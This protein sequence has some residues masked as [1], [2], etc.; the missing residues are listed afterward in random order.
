MTHM[1][2][3]FDGA[4]A[5]NGD[6]SG[7]ET[8]A[9]TSMQRMFNEAVAF[10]SDISSWNTSKV[11][12]MNGMF[13]DA[14]SFNQDISSWD[15]TSVTNA[16]GM[17]GPTFDRNLGKWYVVL[18]NTDIARAPVPRIV[19]E[20]SSQNLQFGRPTYG[21]GDGD[22]KD[23]FEIVNDNQI[24][25]TSIDTK[26][27]YEVNV[28]ASS[29]GGIDSIFSDG[30][31]WRVFDVTVTSEGGT[32]LT[33]GAFV[34]TWETESDSDAVRI[35]L[36]VRSGET[37]TID[38]GDNSPVTVVTTNV[39]RA[40]VYSDSG[41]YQVSMT[42]GL[43]RIHLG[44][45]GSTP[46]FLT[47]IDQWGDDIE[48]S[49]MEGAFQGAT[50][51]EYEA[52]DVPD[53][54]DVT[55]MKDMFREATAFNGDISSWNVASVTDTSSM[56]SET[57][58][59]NQPLNDWNV[60]SVTDMSG[61]FNGA[62]AF[63]QPLNDWTVDS[64]TDMSSMFSETYVFNQPLNDWNVDS[65]TDMSGM[66]SG[67]F[68]FNRP[69]NDWNVDSVTDM[70]GM[71][72]G[73]TDFNRPLN[74]WNVDSV[75][76]MENM[77]AAAT[78][79]NED[80]S[81]WDVSSVT[82]M[83]DM[84]NGADSFNRN[85]GKWYVVLNN[86]DIDRTNVPGIVGEISA[87][88]SWLDS[89][90]LTYDIGTGGDSDL[91]D[92]VNNNDLNMDSVEQKSAYDVT[93]VVSGSGVFGSGAHSHPLEITVTGSANRAPTADAGSDLSV[94]EGGSIAPQGSGSDDDGD[95]LTYSWSQSPATPVVSFG[96]PT[97]ATQTITAPSV[98]ADTE[99]TLT[100]TVNDGTT[101][102][103]D[104]MVLTVRDVT[105]QNLRPTVNVGPNQ[106]VREGAPVSMPWTA[107]DPDADPLTFS[108]S[109]DPASPAISLSSPNSSPTT[110][111]APQ[112]DVDTPFTFTLQVTAGPHTVEDSLTVTVKNN[113]P[114]AVDAGQDRT[115]SEG[116]PVTL[117]GTASDPDA[118]PLTYE[119]TQD[120]GP[121]VTLTNDGTARPQFT[122]PRV[123][124]DQEIVF[125][126][127]VTDDPGES[128]DDTVT[129][130]VRDVPLSVSS[131][132]YNPGSGQL[133]VTLNQNVDSSDI[134]YSAMHIRSTGSDSG[135]ITISGISDKSHSGRTITATLDSE[136]REEYGDMDRPQLDIEGGAITD[137]DGIEL[138]QTL[139]IPISDVSNRKSSSNAP[140]V[141]LGTSAYQR[142]AD[143]PPHIAERIA[144][145][146]DSDPLEPLVPDGTFE[147]PLVINGYGYLLDDS[148]NTLV[149]Q[150]VTTGD[151]DPVTVTFTVYTE[152]D[153]AHFTLYLNL[154]DGNTDYADS[155]T[156]IMY[157]GDGTT[158]VTD[159][160]G[161]V[162]TATITVTQEDDQV[163]EKKTVSITI[164]FD[165]PMGPTNMVVYMW[166]TDRKATFVRMIDALEVVALS[167]PPQEP[168][169][170]AADPEPVEPD[171]D[172]PA[173]PEPIPADTVWS[174]DYDE[175]QVLSLIRMWS[176]FESEMITDEQLL[177]SLGLDD[178]Y[179]DAD[180]PDW[181]M[182]E[183]G[184]LAAKGDV[185]VGEFMLALQYVLEHT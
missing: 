35:P 80:I 104:A 27:V 115:V 43:S 53:L 152:K 151:G 128:A 168:V 163:P 76:I 158:V 118:D 145:R 147:F 155:D 129:V 138:A 48:W 39:T 63:N 169:M 10:N 185:T 7:W 89:Q 150:T 59:F 64:V 165:E 160:H 13:Q 172:L 82:D 92:I 36:E 31:N 46:H 42:G 33:E 60:D 38:W 67:A 108:W 123:T 8:S 106:T 51:M 103:T 23:F 144:S 5:F 57:Y 113:R 84:F 15:I 116:V 14:T 121:S 19:G 56:F 148:I 171:S 3:M 66:F 167:P 183:L 178:D 16:A 24:N 179:P 1:N 78:S 142:L 83:A 20:I 62:E 6:I 146:D 177:A 11:L 32:T 156:Y 174:G 44:A 4:A 45:T 96:N 100:L 95:S 105:S 114:P 75:T 126:L 139:N 73:A 17:L 81:E 164:H 30:N 77:F 86:A 47:S 79:F 137:L 101:A 134:D 132:T 58:D 37:V 133:T 12:S 85:L 120:S 68:V 72:S 149:P 91:F 130:T 69:L 52:T 70:S 166:N 93:V 170:Q 97:S 28:T 161:Y 21:I 157:K 109:Q 122:A 125:R 49:N 124:S 182:T 131:V 41:E 110:F 55:S 34:T 175:A 117:S 135:G 2:F 18:N 88:N 127:A 74:D 65:V 180:I 112:V 143:I 176:G 26:S 50:N 119:W 87:Q 99:I 71:F 90:S 40:H 111:I 140:A 136:Q 141:N 102:A 153:L 25:M 54:S 61:M 181:V 107:V 154:Q 9:V 184:V 159:P 98:A 29:P 162:D 173:D 94:N 22:D